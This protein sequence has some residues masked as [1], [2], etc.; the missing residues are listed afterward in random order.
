MRD[1]LGLAEAVEGKECTKGRLHTEST[2][3]GCS[4]LSTNEGLVKPDQRYLWP[5]VVLFPILIWSK[6]FPQTLA[7]SDQGNSD[8]EKRDSMP[9]EQA[10]VSPLQL[11]DG[12]EA[13]PQPPQAPDNP[14]QNP[15]GWS[16]AIYPVMGW[17]PIFGTSVTLPPSPSQPITMPG[18]SGSTDS[19]LNAAYFG[20][21]RIE[22]GK[23]STDVLFMWAALSAHHESPFAKV[24]LDFVFGD[25]MAGREVLPNFYVEGGAR[26][27]A[28]D[29][30]A[31]VE[32]STA[33][34]SPGFWDPLI[35]LTYRRQLGKKWRIFIHGDGGGFGVGSDVDVTA[36]GRAEWQ[37]ARHFGL[38]MGYGGLHFS[39]SDS[40]AGR[41]LKISPTLHGPIFGFGI[42]F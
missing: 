20:G 31:T 39:K 37:F 28:L 34:R 8:F 15:Y 18:P 17:A 27:L 35:G 29:I 24:D 14:S 16:I 38:A 42:F 32:S 11:E 26:R 9:I 40:A 30:H 7:I 36:T 21:A 12:S 22:K 3:K 5:I 33:S 19:A 13:S 23:W 10:S 1:N 4:A 6:A 2:R 25:I 41:T